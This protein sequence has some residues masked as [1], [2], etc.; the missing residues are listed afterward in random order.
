MGMYRG[1][2]ASIKEY[3]R[4]LVQG[5]CSTVAMLRG[6]VLVCLYTCWGLVNVRGS[7]L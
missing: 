3:T 1:I 5:S 4:T 2:G 7:G 6:L